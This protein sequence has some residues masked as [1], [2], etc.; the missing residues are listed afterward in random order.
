MSPAETVPMSAVATEHRLSPRAATNG[1]TTRRIAVVPLIAT[2]RPPTDLA[3]AR[4]VIRLPNVKGAPNNELANRV[5]IWPATLTAAAPAIVPVVQVSVTA[6]Q[7]AASAI[8]QVGPTES[9]AG[10]SPVRAAETVMRLE[11]DP[12][13]TTGQVRVAAAVAA[14]PA[15][16]LEEDL[17]VVVVEEAVAPVVVEV[18]GAGNPPDRREEITGAST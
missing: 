15:C 9:A 2:A 4:E 11:A 17:A 16:H 8:A 1:S 13:G 3:G 5:G 10:M 7:E 18:A 14:H 12:E 6:A